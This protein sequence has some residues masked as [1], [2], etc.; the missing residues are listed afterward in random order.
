MCHMF[1]LTYRISPNSLQLI[2]PWYICFLTVCVTVVNRWKKGDVVSIIQKQQVSSLM[3]WVEG[4]EWPQWW[5]FPVEERPKARVYGYS[6]I[7]RSS[8]R[9]LNVMR[10]CQPTG[11]MQF[12]PQICNNT[13]QLRLHRCL[14][15][16]NGMS[17]ERTDYAGLICATKPEKPQRELPF[18]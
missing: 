18:C 9:V 17:E 8:S 14:T 13:L 2:A 10:K 6:N 4:G 11:K 15:C 7:N 3:H 5:R 12:L 1:D 16:F